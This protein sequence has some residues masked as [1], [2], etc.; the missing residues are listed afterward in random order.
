MDT[1]YKIEPKESQKTKPFISI[2]LASSG[3]A[4]TGRKIKSMSASIDHKVTAINGV[5]M[6]DPDG[7]IWTKYED[8]LF[9]IAKLR[10]ELHTKNTQIESLTETIVQMSMELATAKAHEDE[11]SMKLRTSSSEL[12]L[13]AAAKK[14]AEEEKSRST[15]RRASRMDSRINAHSNSIAVQNPSA[16][17]RNSRTNVFRNKSDSWALRGS[18]IDEETDEVKIDESARSRVS[19]FRLGW[20]L[21]GELDTS[22]KD[23][24][25]EGSESQKSDKQKNECP[26]RGLGSFVRS[27]SGSHRNNGNGNFTESTRKPQIEKDVVAKEVD[28]FASDLRRKTSKPRDNSGLN[29]SCVVFPVGSSDMISAFFEENGKPTIRG[30]IGQSSNKNADWGCM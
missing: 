24:M 9:E 26:R 28:T 29:S 30:R 8:A 27:L 6:L 11:L 10:E 12:K 19:G 17:R 1:R 15:T 7:D 13:D 21:A 20:G 23:T 16:D 18:E 3:V 4:T 25:I 22:N 5:S 14:M 2:S